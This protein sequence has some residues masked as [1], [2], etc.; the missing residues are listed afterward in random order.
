[1]ILKIWVCRNQDS[2]YRKS[3]QFFGTRKIGLA[4]RYTKSHVKYTTGTGYDGCRAQIATGPANRCRATRN[5]PTTPTSV[6]VIS[7]SLYYLSTFSEGLSR[8]TCMK[9]G[10]LSYNLY[11]VSV[12]SVL[13][14]MMTGEIFSAQLWTC[15]LIW[16]VA[17]MY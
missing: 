16:T 12:F 17:Y 11:G 13:F 10:R 8:K 3:V 15:Y 5:R 6:H 7:S 4:F 2:W 1:M 14:K 9:N